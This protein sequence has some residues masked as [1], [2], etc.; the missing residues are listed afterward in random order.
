LIKNWVNKS[1]EHLASIKGKDL[2]MRWP[3]PQAF[4]G[5]PLLKAEMRRGLDP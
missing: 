1:I 3:S 4:L 2:E 5:F